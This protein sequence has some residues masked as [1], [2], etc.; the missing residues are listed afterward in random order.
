L[1]LLPKFLSELGGY[2]GYVYVL[3]SVV[4]RANRKAGKNSRIKTVKFELETRRRN[5]GMGLLS[6]KF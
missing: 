6:R 3:L 1:H 5:V 2:K 4:E